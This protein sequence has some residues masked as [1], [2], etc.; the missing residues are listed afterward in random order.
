MSHPRPEYHPSHWT[1]VARTCAEEAYRRHR[2]SRRGVFHVPDDDVLTFYDNCLPRGSMLARDRIAAVFRRHLA[3][4]GIQVL[5]TATYPRSGPDD[6]R[7]L[8]VVLDAGEAQEPT[9]T[10]AWDTAR[11]ELSWPGRG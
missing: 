11:R 9:V 2:D 4:A 5:A 6:G 10:A 7:T 1:F 3:A 8:A